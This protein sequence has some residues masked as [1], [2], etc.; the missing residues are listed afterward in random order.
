MLYTYFKLAW[1]NLLKNKTTSFV[2]I[3][4]LALGI[5]CFFLLGTYIINELRFDSFHKKAD[6]IVFMSFGYKAPSEEEFTET[7]WTPNA[8]VPAF[9]EQFPEIE[10]GV[11]LYKRGSE[12]HKVPVQYKG[13]VFNEDG[14]VFADEPF[15]DV[16]SFDFIK[17]NPAVALKEPNSIVITE[18]T[19]KR[20]FGEEEALGESLT[21]NNTP[22]KVT[23][24]IK[25]IPSYSQIQFNII[26]PY[27]SLSRFKNVSWGAANDI[28]YLLLKSPDDIAAV[29]SKID[30]YLKEQFAEEIAA[31]YQAKFPLQ[32]LL[33]VRLHSP[34]M[35][36][37]K[38]IY[39][40]LLSVVAI[41]LLL[42]ACINFG[43][44]IMTKS[45]ERAH[46]IGVRKVIGASRK[47]IFT[48]FVTESFFTSIIALLVGTIGAILLIPVFNSYTGIQLSLESW[49][50]GWFI[51]II[52]LL[53]LCISFIS[54]GAPAWILSSVKP[55]DSLKGKISNSKKGA[56]LS[57]ILIIFQF[58]LS[59]LFI[60]STLI[61][62]GQMRYLQS[63]D[64][65]ISRSKV[66]VLDASELAV[67]NLISFKNT[68]TSNNN[69]QGVTASYDS[70]VNINGGYTLETNI[71]SSAKSINITGIPVEK[72]FLSVFDIKLM[73][74]ESFNEGDVTRSGTTDTEP[75][76][77]FIINKTALDQ[78]GLKAD[79]A[80]GKPVNLNGRKGKIK[81]V[82][83]DFNFA[84]L[85]Q[86][87]G[88]IVLFV[89]YSWFGKLMIKLKDTEHTQ[90]TLGF[91]EDTWKKFSKDKPFEY[92]YLEEEYNGLYR[93]EERTLK[94]LTLFSV[95]TILVSGLGLFA[96]S[97]LVIQRR[98]KEIGIRKI[99]GASMFS[100]VKLVSSEFLK[101]VLLSL[102]IVTPFS[103]WIMQK[104]LQGFAY[105]TEIRWEVFLFAA[106]IGLLIT[107]LTVSFQA[108]RIAN[109]NPINS[110]RDE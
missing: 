49:K 82:S 108:I 93:T 4:S 18:S 25:D 27:H 46:E 40:Y 32:K 80:I 51:L 58:S 14:L 106:V 74:G 21:M 77:A 3:V 94:I 98:V 6:R 72:D 95:A 13:K 39:I 87:I 31:G 38:Q 53:F 33:D 68:L 66:I 56:L 67:T 26:G 5:C 65:G 43:N 15:F 64:T 61:V 54:G 86:K 109:S 29:Q 92:H 89:E 99:L 88:P 76:Y 78:L 11:R 19:A 37:P 1:R 30:N 97:S 73:A 34:V 100:I 23:G 104:W 36:G 75:E 105:R 103:W 35:G 22:W 8:A 81:A 41:S 90:E 42:I 96:L 69:I 60:I 16:F 110:L 63:K 52:I 10:K 85:H 24:V 20:Y 9:A 57:K 70:P 91:L 45:S 62:N 48:Q 50:G 83:K 84:S 107:A 44:L 7:P 2:S 102:I 79:E 12:E 47:H 59:L 101:L 28:S 71:N 55:T 17:G